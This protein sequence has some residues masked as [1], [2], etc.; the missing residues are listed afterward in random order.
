MREK[1][2]PKEAKKRRKR[3]RGHNRDA[4]NAPRKSVYDIFINFLLLELL[5]E[6][7]K[8]VKRLRQS[9][10]IGYNMESGGLI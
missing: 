9:L 1:A 7:T 6:D 4:A 2:A 3:N 8:Y 5:I 10:T